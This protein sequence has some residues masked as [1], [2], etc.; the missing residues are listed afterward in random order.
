MDLAEVCQLCGATDQAL[1]ALARATALFEVKGNVVL[2]RSAAIMAAD[3]QA[4]A[5][6]EAS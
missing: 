6:R 3:L 4:I 2:A 5:D 1:G